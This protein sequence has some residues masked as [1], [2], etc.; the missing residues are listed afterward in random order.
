MNQR[1]VV[2]GTDFHAPVNEGAY[3]R[4]EMTDYADPSL[5]NRNIY[6]RMQASEGHWFQWVYHDGAMEFYLD[7]IFLLRDSFGVRWRYWR[8]IHYADHDR[9]NYDT[10]MDGQN[11]FTHYSLVGPYSFAL[12]KMTFRLIVGTQTAGGVGT[13]KIDNVNTTMPYAGPN[14]PP[15]PVTGSSLSAD[16]PGRCSVKIAPPST[17]LATEALPP[18]CSATWRTIDRPSPLP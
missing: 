14:H 10:S 13:V 11:W 12:D 18:C 4:F 2:A 16:M 9:V 7:N 15:T 6:W 5:N 17:A 8:V 3:A 1:I